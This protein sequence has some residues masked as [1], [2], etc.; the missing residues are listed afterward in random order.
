MRES[1]F[2]SGATTCY[3]TVA[4]HKL[5]LVFCVFRKL[6]RNP[7]SVECFDLAQGCVSALHLCDDID[8]CVCFEKRKN[9]YL[10]KFV[11]PRSYVTPQRDAQL[12]CRYFR[13]S[14]RRFSKPVSRSFCFEPCGLLFVPVSCVCNITCQPFWLGGTGHVVLLAAVLSF[15]M[16]STHYVFVDSFLSAFLLE[17]RSTVAIGSS[18]ARW[19]STARPFRTRCSKW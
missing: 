4:V 2:D 14:K 11:Y 17:T 18:A 5:F 19:W 12:I 8:V 13:C 1:S 15:S 3:T 7:T 16:W 10:C 9:E 6:K